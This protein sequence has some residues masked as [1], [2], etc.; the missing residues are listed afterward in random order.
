[1]EYTKLHKM[2]LFEECSAVMYVTEEDYK[3]Y[4]YDLNKFGELRSRKVVNFEKGQ[5]VGIRW[6]DGTESSETIQM[7]EYP[8]SHWHGTGDIPPHMVLREPYIISSINGLEVKVDD[9][10]ELE[11]ALKNS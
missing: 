9:L 4:G 2:R 8:V 3:K 6:P 7:R 1:M 5:V 10:S 11:I